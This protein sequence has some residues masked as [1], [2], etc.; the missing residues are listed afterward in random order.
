MIGRT[1]LCISLPAIRTGLYQ[2]FRYPLLQIASV[3]RGPASLRG[4]S[5][6]QPNVGTVHALAGPREDGGARS[7]SGA[8]NSQ[9]SPTPNGVHQSS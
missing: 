5:A 7:P 4:M 1:G 2:P 3:A 6:A 9:I 8:Q